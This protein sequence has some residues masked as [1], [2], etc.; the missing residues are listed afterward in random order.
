MSNDW[1]EDEI[2]AS[3]VAYNEMLEHEKNGVR[4]SKKQ[5]YRNL[6]V[7]FGRTE[8]AF[9]Y[10]MQN[11]SHVRNSMGEPWIKGLKPAKNVGNRIASKIEKELILSKGLNP[12]QEPQIFRAT[13]LLKDFDRDD[14]GVL[15]WPFPTGADNDERGY[16][17]ADLAEWD[18]QY[19]G[20]AI[21]HKTRP[22]SGVMRPTIT[23]TTR[24]EYSR[25]LDV[26]IWVIQR[27]KG[28]CEC[29]GKP[30]PFSTQN[31]HPFLEVHHIRQLANGGSDRVSNA[32]AVCPNCHRE[33]H[34]GSRSKALVKRL[35]ANVTELKPE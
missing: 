18:R 12:E 27:C 9:E 25:R 19:R 6:A 22:P 16:T 26:V 32:I 31:G 35:Y 17:S 7:K 8:K 15:I 21:E 30:A 13:A 3:V 23:V 10:R 2:V 29:C 11:I 5:F 24:N 1:N 4:Y 14:K 34:H 33:L 28:N 20:G